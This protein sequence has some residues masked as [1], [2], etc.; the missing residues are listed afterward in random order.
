MGPGWGCHMK[1]QLAPLILCSLP[2]LYLALG[3][4]APMLE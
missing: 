4:D 1:M 3:Q 2:L